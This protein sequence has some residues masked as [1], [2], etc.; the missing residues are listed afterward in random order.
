MGRGRSKEQRAGII[1]IKKH[2]AGRAGAKSPG[3]GMV[4][5]VDGGIER[6][7]QSH[8]YP[9]LEVPR[10]TCPGWELNPGLPCGKR[11]L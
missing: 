11:A 5:T 7:D 8:L 2:S 9:N 3:S 6:L 1:R 4:T 10:L